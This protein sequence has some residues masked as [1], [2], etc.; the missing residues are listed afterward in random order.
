MLPSTPGSAAMRTFERIRS[1][2]SQPMELPQYGETVNLK[3]YTGVATYDGNMTPLELIDHVKIALES[4][5]R[6]NTGPLDTA[7]IR[8]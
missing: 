4:T 8:Q 5:R 7:R 2:I 3:P 6:G 1:A